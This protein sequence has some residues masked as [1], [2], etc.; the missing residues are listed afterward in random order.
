HL[1]DVGLARPSRDPAGR[2]PVGVHEVSVDPARCANEAEEQ[3]RHEQ[4]EPGPP[5]QIA[6]HPVA[7]CDAVMPTL[8]RADDLD[9]DATGTKTRNLDRLSHEI[10][11]VCSTRPGKKYANAPSGEIS[12]SVEPICGRTASSAR[13][14]AGKTMRRVVS[15]SNCFAAGVRR[16]WSQPDRC[17]PS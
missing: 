5:A 2:K 1:H 13:L 10:G 4:P 3:R 6:E 7:V 8:L 11:K 12:L 17:R 16:H 9:V 15:R 14:S